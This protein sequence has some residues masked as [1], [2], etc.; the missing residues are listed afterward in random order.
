M[1]KFENFSVYVIGFDVIGH[2]VIGI[3]VV[4]TDKTGV[5]QYG[6]ENGLVIHVLQQIFWPNWNALILAK[7]VSKSPKKFY[8]CTSRLERMRLKKNHLK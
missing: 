3:P 6:I 2:D 5:G 8:R 7:K 4:Q 1:R